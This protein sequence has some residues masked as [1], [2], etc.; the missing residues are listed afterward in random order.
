MQISKQIR[1][2]GRVGEDCAEVFR[3]GDS[4]VFALA[5][6]AGGVSGGLRAAESFIAFVREQIDTD[7]FDCV[8]VVT[9][10]NGA[11]AKIMDDA[12][13][14]ET[15]AIIVIVKNDKIIGASAG[16]SEVWMF[17]AT[18][19]VQLTRRQARSRRLGMA[20]AHPVAFGPVEFD[21]TLVIASDGLW[22][23]LDISRIQQ[24]ALNQPLDV[25]ADELV[26]AVRLRSG[27]LQDD[28]AI[29]L[30]RVDG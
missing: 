25:A 17:G 4:T 18:D 19:S 29:I 27:A 5:D 13:A 21:G 3:C 8:D 28:V 24:I 22:K 9:L 11:N 12:A 30:C 6:G 1:A 26:D 2:S 15:T 16:D 14:G 23:Y 20:D 10:L 7:R